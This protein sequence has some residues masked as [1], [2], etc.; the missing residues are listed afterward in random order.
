VTRTFVVGTAGHV[1]HGKTTLVRALTGIDTD[2]LPEEKRRGISIELGFAPWRLDG[3]LTLTVVDVP[4][5]RRLVH[6]MIAGASGIELVLLVIAANEGVMPQ[7]R[8]HARVCEELGITHAVVVLTKCDLV[9]A[10]ALILAEAEARD[11]LEGRFEVS[12]VACSALHGTGLDHLRDTVAARLRALPPRTSEGPARLWVDRVLSV[13]GAG[14]VVTGTLSSGTITQGEGLTLFGAGTVRKIA[15][16]ELRVHEHVIEVAASPTRLA[17]NLAIDVKDVHRGDLLT[18]DTALTLTN[19]VDAFLSDVRVTRGADISVHTGSAHVSARLTRVEELDEHTQL[20]R[21]ALDVPRPLRG[22]DRFVVRGISASKTA[23]VACGG[24]VFD[25][26]PHARSRRAARRALA[27]ATRAGD[28]PQVLTLLLRESAPHPV[29]TSALCERLAVDPKAVALAAEAGVARGELVRVGSGVLA[30]ATLLSLAD[31]ARSLVANHMAKA[32][33]DRGLPLATLRQ[34]LSECA[35]P[36]AAEEA[37]RA[38]RTPRS[39]DD[40]GR[41]VIEGDAVV[42]AV[43]SS[44]IDPALTSAV[45]RARTELV[46]AGAR[47]VSA[48]RV[49]ELTGVSLGHVRALMALLSRQ[50]AA[51]PVG[52]LWFAQEFVEEIR[53]RLVRHLSTRNGITVIEF[54][55]L[56]SLARK[57][58]VHLLEHFD[59]VGLT[60]RKGDVRVLADSK[61]SGAILGQ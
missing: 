27:I 43:R 33:L 42:P 50:G 37:I 17:V 36:L 21:L 51:I 18:S 10:E 45:E 22:G 15:A 3:D 13:R 31:L 49:T 1:D 20:V 47:G 32:P 56:G 28:A 24:T 25:A 57:Q 23:S 2:R 41:I 35:G 8:E 53:R 30:R 12:V 5:H 61:T 29:D 34:M 26:H 48:A 44:S 54:K 16:R 6:T 4:G 52:D 60:H 39:G 7:T 59:Q 58:A 9:D 11:L 55:N 38:A 19:V 46:H 14:T 40:G